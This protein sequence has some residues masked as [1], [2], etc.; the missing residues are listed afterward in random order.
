MKRGDPA[1]GHYVG[2]G[3]KKV[4][5]IVVYKYIPSRAF[6]WNPQHKTEAVSGKNKQSTK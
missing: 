5:S 1:V 2:G 6:L 3:S 4:F